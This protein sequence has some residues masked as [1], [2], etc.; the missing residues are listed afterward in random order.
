MAY[1]A[2]L[3]TGDFLCI[4]EGEDF[5]SPYHWRMDG[6]RDRNTREITC[7]GENAGNPWGWMVGVYHPDPENPEYRDENPYAGSVN[8][9]AYFGDIVA[10]VREALQAAATTARTGVQTF[11]CTSR[12]GEVRVS[13]VLWG[14]NGTI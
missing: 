12:E 1:E 14:A 4:T 6:I 7:P 3:E 10:A 13:E 5:I 9:A 2:K 11:I 8:L